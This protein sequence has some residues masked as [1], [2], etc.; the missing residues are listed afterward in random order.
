[1]NRDHR[2]HHSSEDPLGLWRGIGIGITLGGLLWMV[3]ILVIWYL[4]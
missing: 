1:M 3:I 4:L 2:K